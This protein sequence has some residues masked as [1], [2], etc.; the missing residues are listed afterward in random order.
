[1]LLVEH[2]IDRHAQIA[3][4]ANDVV[5]PQFVIFTDLLGADEQP[6]RETLL[7]QADIAA[8]RDAARFEFVAD[9]AGPADER[10]LMKDRHDIHDIRH[11]HGADEGVIIGED[12][13]VAN[14]G[15]VL[16]AVADHP[17]DE[18][19]HCVDMHHDAVGKRYGIAF[20]RIDRDHH[21]THF[22]NTRR[23]GYAPRHFARR[24]AV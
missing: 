13:A 17:F 22:A 20:G 24:Y 3:L 16:I 1:G 21:L 9:G 18:T 6:L 4:A 19:A 5:A 2:P 7:R 23:S 8:R 12:V 10:P 14:G 15:I 11:L